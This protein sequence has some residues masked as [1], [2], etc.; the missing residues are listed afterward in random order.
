M[1]IRLLGRFFTFFIGEKRKAG[2]RGREFK[3]T[4]CECCGHPLCN[5]DLD[6]NVWYNQD[7]NEAVIVE[8]K[9]KEDF[10][11]FKSHKIVTRRVIADFL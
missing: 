1:L 4:V 8:Y 7:K 3:R 9:R 6:L 5:D 2:E 11:G 10:M